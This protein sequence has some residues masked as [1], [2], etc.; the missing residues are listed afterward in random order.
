MKKMNPNLILCGKVDPA[1]SDLNQK[2]LQNSLV[3]A[4]AAKLFGVSSRGLFTRVDVDVGQVLCKYE[5]VILTQRQ[6]FEQEKLRT[7][8]FFMNAR[9]GNGKLVVINGDPRH[10]GLGGFSNYAKFTSANAM[11]V[12]DC[13]SPSCGKQSTNVLLVAKESIRKG[14]EIRVDYDTGC[15]SRPF[16]QMMLQSGIKQEDLDDDAFKFKLWTEPG[17]NGTINVED[18]QIP[19][20]N[21]SSAMACVAKNMK[22]PLKWL[23][24]LYE[25]VNKKRHPEK[26]AAMDPSSSGTK[27]AHLAE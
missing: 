20:V 7:C 21:L 8:E 22:R 17:E 5:G 12:D 15:Q 19:N 11:F 23:P 14:V 3:Y 26:N 16:R 18:P 9:T 10:L 2:I 13:A 27:H 4:A 1:P 6:A 25:S 24:L